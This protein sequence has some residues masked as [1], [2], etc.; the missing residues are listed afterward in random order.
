MKL[1]RMKILKWLIN[2]LSKILVVSV[3]TFSISSITAYGT[4]LNEERANDLAEI[5]LSQEQIDKVHTIS[6]LLWPQLDIE[7]VNL[8]ESHSLRGYLLVIFA[9]IAENCEVPSK[10]IRQLNPV[11]G[12]TPLSALLS[13]LTELKKLKKETLSQACGSAAAVHGKAE[14]QHRLNE[15]RK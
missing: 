15:A 11:N 5:E 1:D 6:K 4:M 10:V 3:F 8:S 2:W 14:L 7:S 13:L 9:D 12:V